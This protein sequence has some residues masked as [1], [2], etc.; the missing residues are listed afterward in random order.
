[1]SAYS[2]TFFTDLLDPTFRHFFCR[3]LSNTPMTFFTHVRYAI[4]QLL[5]PPLPHLAYAYPHI[6]IV[7][8]S[9][10]THLT[11]EH[12]TWLAS[13]LD[14]DDRWG[15]RHWH[16]FIHDTSG[17]VVGIRF[18]IVSVTSDRSHTARVVF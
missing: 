10:V 14:W 2:E 1:M 17:D 3:Q 15:Y 18:L 11:G 13:L 12:R 4:Q 9:D 8:D 16:R 5:C 6:H 7:A